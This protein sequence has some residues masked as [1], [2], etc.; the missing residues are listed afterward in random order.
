MGQA[1]KNE[2]SIDERVLPKKRGR[3]RFPKARVRQSDLLVRGGPKGK[4][5]GIKLLQQGKKG[6][7]AN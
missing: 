3:G 7:R 6:A 5:G 4:G 2:H 1:A